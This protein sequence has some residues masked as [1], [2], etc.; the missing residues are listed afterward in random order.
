MNWIG[1]FWTGLINSNF[2]CMIFKP[3]VRISIRYMCY[4]HE[5]NVE[6]VKKLFRF[7]FCWPCI[8]LQFFAND[9]LDALFLS[10]FITLLHTFR[11]SQCSSSGDRIVLIHHLVW[12]VCVTAWYA[13]Q[14]YQA[15]N[16]TDLSYQM[17]Y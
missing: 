14:A 17:M 10:L 1:E 16:H 4:I 12:L 7:I 8:S 5:H 15:V 2:C 13:G 3:L 9:Q 11:A 6:N